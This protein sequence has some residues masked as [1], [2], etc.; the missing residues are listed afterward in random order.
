MLFTK[1]QSLKLSNKLKS[2]KVAKLKDDDGWVRGGTMVW[3]LFE[4][5]CDSMC[6]GVCDCVSDDVCVML[7]GMFCVMLHVMVWV[8]DV[9]CD[10]VSDDVSSLVDVG[11]VKWLILC[12]LGVLIYHRR[13]DERTFVLL[14]SLSWLKTQGNNLR[15]SK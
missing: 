13:T 1:F 15:M 6:D 14:E 5:V 2:L 4:S 10:G 11:E 7:G 8:C 9:V 3:G 12:C